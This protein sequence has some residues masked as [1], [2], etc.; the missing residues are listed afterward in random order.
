MNHSLFTNVEHTKEVKPNKYQEVL[1]KRQRPAL[2][3]DQISYEKDVELVSKSKAEKKSD[4]KK[5]TILPNDLVKEKATEYF[6]GDELAA[7]VWINKYAL[8]D[9]K[10]NIY[11]ETPDDMHWR[12]ANEIARIEKKIS[13][14]IEC[15][16]NL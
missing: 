16:G 7:N 13:Q 3:E 15:T 8:K 14:S 5:Y 6:K 9:S 12:L 1:E 10:G 2:P 4:Q 11:E